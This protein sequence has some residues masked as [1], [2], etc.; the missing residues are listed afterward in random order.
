MTIVITVYSVQSTMYELATDII[1]YPKFIPSKV[2]VC[3]IK[4]FLFQGTH[5]SLNH[6]HDRIVLTFISIKK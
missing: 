6:I 3:S 2:M 4:C 5:V 1:C